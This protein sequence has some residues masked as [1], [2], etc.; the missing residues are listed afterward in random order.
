MSIINVLGFPVS[1]SG[2]EADVLQAVRLSES[3]ECCNYM[4]C[5]NPH[6][7]VLAQ[8]D[9]LFSSALRNS[10]LL[11]P[12]GAGILVAGRIL[13]H[14]FRERV[15]GFEFFCAYSNWV[16][17]RRGA[18]YFFLGSTVPVLDRIVAR[19]GCDFP[20]IQVV[21]T[22][23][24]P[25]KEEFSETENRDITAAIN[26]AQ[27][28]VLWVGMTAPKQEKW[29]LNNRSSL[30]VPLAC[31]VGAVFDFY[32]GT[33]PRAPHWVGQLGLEWLPRMLREPARLWR[34]TLISSPH[35]LSLVI[36]QKL[37]S[38]PLRPHYQ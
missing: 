12:D 8:N 10:D 21:G 38:S 36:R 33:K 28:D 17:Q 22:L 32:A 6:S 24:P 9:R 14:Q 30:K 25:F 35:F 31:A 3:S 11:V 5:A 19:L 13:N 26:A 29:I 34:R 1:S 20:A 15:A 4:A 16:Q 7:L 18:R 37:S 2:L 27:P 23:S